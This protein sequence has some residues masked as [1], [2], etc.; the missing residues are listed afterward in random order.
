M[1]LAR[2]IP[3]RD[4]FIFYMSLRERGLQFMLAAGMLAGGAK[5]AD[6]KPGNSG[7]E[8]SHAASTQS[9]KEDGDDTFA[10][11]DHAFNK[12]HDSHVEQVKLL[13]L[14]VE[15]DVMAALHFSDPQKQNEFQARLK[16]ALEKMLSNPDLSSELGKAALQQ[17]LVQ[18]YTRL[19]V[20]KGFGTSKNY[21][22]KAE[23][24]PNEKKL[25]K[26]EFVQGT[27]QIDF[28]LE[29]SGE[30]DFSGDGV[31]HIGKYIVGYNFVAHPLLHSKNEGIKYPVID[32]ELVSYSVRSGCKI[33]SS[34]YFMT[35][36]GVRYGYRAI[37]K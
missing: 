8:K 24:P 23:T 5:A 28:D 30:P 22:K 33:S 3:S 37:A 27:P 25:V 16:K 31:Q 11:M 32:A 6:A 13:S 35:K 29:P 2:N 18:T 12:E 21:E 14:T 26:T 15:H 19:A 34:T 9:A 7:L 17:E 20:E 10:D 4:I 36:D 1:W